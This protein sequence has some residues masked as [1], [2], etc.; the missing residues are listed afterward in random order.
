MLDMQAKVSGFSRGEGS[1]EVLSRQNK[2]L[3]FG[4][5]S[6]GAFAEPSE[7]GSFLGS[8][9]KKSLFSSSS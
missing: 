3:P 6:G 5:G 9:F 8:K 7:V 1:K 2:I 4:S